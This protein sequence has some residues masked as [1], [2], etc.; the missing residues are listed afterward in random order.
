MSTV[1]EIEE[2]AAKLPPADLAR[3]LEDLRDLQIAR[4]ALAEVVSG[5]ETTV[6]LDR[7]ESELNA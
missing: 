7:L 3:L 6:S 5:E 4:T 2:A 1:T